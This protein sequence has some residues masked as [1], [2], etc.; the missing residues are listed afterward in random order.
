MKSVLGRVS[1]LE[2]RLVP[3]GLIVPSGRRRLALDND[4]C[5]EIF[6]DCGRLSEARIQ[7]IVLGTYPKA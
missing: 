3:S 6:R 2:Q 5:I 7:L 4:T 1:R